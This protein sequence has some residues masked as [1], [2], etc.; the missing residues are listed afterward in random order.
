MRTG[1]GIFLLLLVCFACCNSNCLAANQSEAQ[2]KSNDP[3]PN[4]I[5]FFVDDLGYGDLGFT[6]H[7]TIKTPNLDQLAFHGKILT[8]WYSGCNVCTGSRSALMTGR[9]WTRT[10]LPGV[11]GPTQSYGLN[12]KEIT[13]AEQLKKGGYATG[14]VGKWH[15]GQRK[16]YLPGSRG[17]DYYLGIPFSDDMGIAWESQCPA[18][19]NQEPLLG[20]DATIPLENEHLDS[21]PSRQMYEQSGLLKAMF[22]EEE[23]TKDK[24]DPPPD[25]GAKWLPL[26]YQE[27]NK[28]RI[29]EQPL[30]FT[31]LAQKYSNFATTF[32]ENHQDSPFF[33]YVPFSHVHCTAWGSTKEKQYAGCDFQGATERGTFGDALAETDWIAGTIVQKLRDLDLEENTLILFTSDNGPWMT[34]KL[35]GGSAGLFTGRFAEGYTNTAKGTNWEGGIR[36]PAFAYWKGKINPFSRSSEVISSMDVFPTLSALAGI[37]LPDDRPYDGKDMSQILLSQD[38]KSNHDF[39]FFYGDCM[40]DKYYSV[41]SVRHGKYKAH[42]CTSPG[43]GPYNRTELTKKYD[44]PLLFDVEKDPSEA[45]PISFNAMPEKA[46]DLEAM[47]RILSAY[48]MEKSTFQFGNITKEPD[49]PG[50]GPGHYALCCDRSKD[51]YCHDQ[52]GIFNLGTKRHHD[53]YHKALGE[54]E[55]SPPRTRY[56]TMLRNVE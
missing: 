17:F 51:C 56:Q 20:D 4:F 27:H 45:E 43:L 47:K 24:P 25:K 52:V 16:V 44:P 5:V 53:E 37:P 23:G 14:I 39:L 30:D 33:L 15:L 38:G 2:S 42:W 36:E 29:L 10:G 50:E 22:H 26:V 9:Q 8:T 21:W 46:E 55:P 54:E 32:I 6:G 12:L 34:M 3:P 35:S 28:T 41:T 49:G 19:S 18:D 11:I 31:T 13:L 1:A 7:P 48:A 40:G